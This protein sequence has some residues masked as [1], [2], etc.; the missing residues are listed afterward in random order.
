MLLMKE[1]S[2]QNYTER[3]SAIKMQYAV[4]HISFFTSRLSC[5]DGFFGQYTVDAKAIYVVKANKLISRKR[6]F[7]NLRKL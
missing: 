6:E 5:F 1:K 4:L 3:K 2:K 7:R